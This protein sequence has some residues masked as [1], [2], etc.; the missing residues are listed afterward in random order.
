M[1]EQVQKTGRPS[2]ITSSVVQKLEQAFRDD[3]GITTACRL[4]QISTSTYYQHLGNDPDFSDKMMF[5]QEWN[6]MRAKEVIVG[7]IER[8]DV[9]AAKWYL[10]RKA[11]DEFSTRSSTPQTGIETRVA[12]ITTEQWEGIKNAVESAERRLA[13]P[14]KRVGTKKDDN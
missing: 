11:R 2:V 4:A 14:D 12:N 1:A 8:G 7:A 9:S 3:L 13:E 5:A 10:E 6:V